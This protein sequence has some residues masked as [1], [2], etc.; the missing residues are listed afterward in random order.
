M[1]YCNSYN[2]IGYLHSPHHNHEYRYKNA[3]M[4][5]G[6]NSNYNNVYGHNQY[7][8]WNGMHQHHPVHQHPHS[9]PHQQPYGNRN[10]SSATCHYDSYKT[11]V[12]QNHFQ[13]SA[14][15]SYSSGNFELPYESTSQSVIPTNALYRSRFGGYQMCDAQQCFPNGDNTRP[16]YMSLGGG[17]MSRCSD[18]LSNVNGIPTVDPR[19]HHHH[20]AYV[21]DVNQHHSHIRIPTHRSYDS[22]SKARQYEATHHHQTWYGN[23]HNNSETIND[24][25]HHYYQYHAIN[26]SN[27]NE[28]PP[29]HINSNG[30]Q[31][32]AGAPN[33]K[34]L[35]Y[36]YVFFWFCFHFFYCTIFAKH[37]NSYMCRFNNIQQV[38]TSIIHAH[39]L[40]YAI[41]THT[42]K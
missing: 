40:L 26:S 29:H 14:T 20:Q 30:N 34:T 5:V 6:Y 39:A 2:G 7:I 35:L 42:Y 10:I 21:N 32:A 1:E 13:S 4:K 8:N 33:G 24:S 37:F 28:Y 41:L 18:P 31:Y 17:G 38:A 36:L 9:H 3:M 22:H 23:Q 15:S 16:D 25:N 27:Y 11:N 12:V 19:N